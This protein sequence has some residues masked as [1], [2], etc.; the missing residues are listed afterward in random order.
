M[1][2]TE[3]VFVGTGQILNVNYTMATVDFDAEDQFVNVDLS[4][5]VIINVSKDFLNSKLGTLENNQWSN[6]SITL[7]L[8]EIKN[9]IQL[10][11][12]IL[13][14]G[15]ISNVNLNYR[16]YVQNTFFRPETLY[17]DEEWIQNFDTNFDK[18]TFINLVQEAENGYF[19][20]HN[21][22][23]LFELWRNSS[24]NTTDY[25]I[26]DGFIEDHYLFFPYGISLVYSNSF[27][28]NTS[29]TQLGTITFSNNYNIVF[30][31]VN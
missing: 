8:T 6:S 19:T 22:N 10:E 12:D 1:S 15:T 30:K 2:D 29:A 7:D 5:D 27:T 26:S 23:S 16:N 28:D 25:Q 24:N 31:I 14:L 3:T 18:T 17:A 20:L 21:T 13:S 9:L 11:S 4:N